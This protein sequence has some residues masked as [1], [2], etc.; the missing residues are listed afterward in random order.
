MKY[1]YE[2][3]ELEE[4]EDIVEKMN[5]WGKDGWRL[6]Y[7]NPALIQKPVYHSNPNPIEGTTT[8]LAKMKIVKECI[9][10]RV[11]ENSGSN[12]LAFRRSNLTTTNPKPPQNN[13]NILDNN[14]PLQENVKDREYKD[15]V[16]N[17]PITTNNEVVNDSN[18]VNPPEIV[19]PD[20]DAPPRVTVVVPCYQRPQRTMRAIE[21]LNNQT[22]A[23]FE[24]LFI[25]DNCPDFG[26]KLQMGRF[27][28]IKDEQKQ[29][30]RSYQFL[31]FSKHAGGYGFAARNY[32]K[33]VA[34]GKYIVFLDNDD[35]IKPNHLEHYLSE[36]ENTNLDW[37]YYDTF[38][39]PKD[40]IRESKIHRGHIGHAELIIRTEFYKNLPAQ[41]EHY[42]HDWDMILDM[43]RS[44]NKF[45]KAESKETTY[46]VR[47]TQEQREKGID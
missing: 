2:K 33:Q 46:M 42:G 5:E 25:G 41:K 4:F 37:V 21:S 8:V 28:F 39:V 22:L 45:K 24:V 11:L 13:E 6:V 15:I 14:N 20:L 43:Q 16:N 47:S 35:T 34:T 19:T 40:E 31:N 18:V 38:V 29:R 32:A 44:S 12:N 23:N 7:Y 30:G 10:E 36:I 17:A 9:V 1:Q 26:E 3:R 27:E